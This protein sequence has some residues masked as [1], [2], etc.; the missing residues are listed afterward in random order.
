VKE[1]AEHPQT[2]ARNMII[3]AGGVRMPG[4]PIKISGYEDPP[5][6]V[7]APSLDE[8]GASIRREFAPQTVDVA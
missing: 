4:N 8:H 5:L 6:R 3:E 7:G 1:A 2:K